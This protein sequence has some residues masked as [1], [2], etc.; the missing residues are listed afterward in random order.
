LTVALTQLFS[1]IIAT[2]TPKIRGL[3]TVK[4]EILRLMET[5]VKKAEDLETVNQSFIP[6]LLDAV[7][8]DYNG[9]APAARDAEVLN[10]MTTITGRLGVRLQLAS[11]LLYTQYDVS[12][13]SVD[14]TNSCCLGCRI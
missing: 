10:V 8:G 6:P 14:A 7:L 3:R 4:K 11:L 13:A 9:N 12:A 1:G 5:Y 2:K